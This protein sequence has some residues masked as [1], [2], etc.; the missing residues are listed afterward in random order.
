M[1]LT[2]HLNGSERT[3]EELEGE[4]K[5]ASLIEALGLR[6]DRVALEQNG[7]IVP[8]TAWH[9]TELRQDDRIELVHFV[10]GG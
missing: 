6:S 9:D 5:I 3:F 2:I 1:P 10:G 7:E 8:R 4:T